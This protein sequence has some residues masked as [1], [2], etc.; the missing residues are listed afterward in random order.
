MIKENDKAV[1]GGASNDEVVK[2][3]EQEPWGLASDFTVTGVSSDGVYISGYEGLVPTANIQRV[4]REE[5]GEIEEIPVLDNMS[6][7]EYREYVM[8]ESKRQWNFNNAKLCG[9]WSDQE[10]RVKVK[11]FNEVYYQQLERID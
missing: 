3:A 9:D 6:L 10:E 4:F 5:N 7:Y 8:G 1:I 2:W 11:F